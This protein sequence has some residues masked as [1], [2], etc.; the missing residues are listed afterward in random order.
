MYDCMYDC[1]CM[2]APLL[3]YSKLERRSTKLPNFQSSIYLPLSFAQDMGLPSGIPLTGSSLKLYR[4]S[5]SVQLSGLE[6]CLAT[7]KENIII[8][9]AHAIDTKF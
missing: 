6:F 5:G 9:I 3:V 4:S 1:I 7:E 8:D 2:I